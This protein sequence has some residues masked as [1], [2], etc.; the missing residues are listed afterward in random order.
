MQ[1]VEYYNLRLSNSTLTVYEPVEGF[2]NCSTPRSTCWAP[3]PELVL[4][5]FELGP[6][7]RISNKFPSDP[8]VLVLEPHV[9][10]HC[11]RETLPVGRRRHTE[12][13]LGWH[14]LEQ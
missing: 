3:S 10:N 5:R 13:C 14:W 1:Y 8:A 11:P 2:S 12:G 6:R 9:K 7:I 4:Q